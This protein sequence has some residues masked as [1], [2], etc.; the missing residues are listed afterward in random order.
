[1]EVLAGQHSLGGY[2]VGIHALPTT[3]QC[4]AME[5]DLQ[6]EIVGIAENILVELHH[7]LL[8][9]SEEIHLDAQDTIL[10]HPF[11]LLAAQ[12]AVVHNSLRGLGGIVPFAV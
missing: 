12:A 11:H 4:T 10:L 3:R 1:M 9:A 2:I 7:H 5:D 8:V 6:A